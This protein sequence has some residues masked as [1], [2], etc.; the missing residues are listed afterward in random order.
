MC[1]GG[2]N[3]RRR[4]WL[5]QGEGLDDAENDEDDV[6]EVEDDYVCISISLTRR[7]TSMHS[8]ITISMHSPKY[9]LTHYY[10]YALIHEHQH[11]LTHHHQHSLTH[12]H[13]HTEIPLGVRMKKDFGVREYDGIVI[14][15]DLCDET[16]RLI[17]H[18]YYHE[19]EDREDLFAEKLRSLSRRGTNKQ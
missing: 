1:C 7:D 5:G 17:Y 13:Q 15:S 2:D 18:V 6:A 19:D 11:A 3:W 16:G 14:S 4:R 12:H 9:T 10:Q 8:H